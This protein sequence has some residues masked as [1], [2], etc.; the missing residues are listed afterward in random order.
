MNNSQIEYLINRYSE[1]THYP[2]KIWVS[3]SKGKNLKSD[4][5]ETSYFWKQININKPLWMRNSNSVLNEEYQKF[6]KEF[7][8][9]SEESIALLCDLHTF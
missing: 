4:R 6:Y 7:T 8:K 9:T 5:N 1:F 2:I 3:E